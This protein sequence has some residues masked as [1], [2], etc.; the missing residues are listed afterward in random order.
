MA[1]HVRRLLVRNLNPMG[2]PRGQLQ[3][4]RDTLDQGWGWQEQGV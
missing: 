4:D 1:G 3:G 2:G